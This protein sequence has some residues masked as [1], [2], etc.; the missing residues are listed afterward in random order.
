MPQKKLRGRLKDKS[1]FIVIAEL[2]GGPDFSFGPVEKFLS[3]Y[4]DVGSSF[5]AEGFDFV[6]IASPHN[7]GGTPN[8]ET[9]N[10]LS[11]LRAQGLLGDLDFIPHISCKDQNTDALIS[12]LAG[13]RAMNIETVLVVTGD[14]PIKGKGVFEL[15]SIGLLQ[16]VKEMN[17][18]SYRKVSL[19]RLEDVHQFFA[20]AVVS[21]FKYTEASLL[22]QYYKMEK[23]ITCN[24]EFLITQV[25]W[26]WKKSIELFR[27]LEENG[28]DIPVIGNVFLLST[29][30]PAPRLMHGLKLPG[31]FVSDRLFAKVC[32]E[33]LDKHIERAAQQVAMYKSIGAAG[34]D[35]GS[36][37]DF[38]IFT[39]IL[40]QASEIGDGW[41]EY[42]DNIY[43]PK[44][45]G[46]YLYDD[47]GQR[48]A[49]S[50][51][52]KRFK[53]KC[54]DFLHRNF[55]SPDRRTFHIIK[56][57][58][59]FLQAQNNQGFAY[60]VFTA[61]EYVIKRFFFDCEMCGD[62]Y[63]PENF[64]LCTI[65]G[66][67]KGMANVPCGDATV[68]GYCGNNF[69]LVCIGELIYKAA[70]SESGGIEQWRAT[71]NKPRIHSLEQTSSI[72]N[73][74][75]GRDH[76]AKGTLISIGESIHA[77]IPKVAKMMKL[78][79]NS[80]AD[81]YSKSSGLL[82]YFKAVIESQAAKNADYI[83]VN[84]DAIAEKN[85]QL[86]VD[87]MVEYV[88]MIRNW[89]KTIP[90]CI[91]SNSNKIVIAGL[92]EWYKTGELIK[93][94]LISTIKLDAMD[95]ILS[96]KKSYDFKFV[97]LLEDIEQPA[98]QIASSSINDLHSFARQI[99]DKAVRE[100]GFKPGEIFFELGLSPL[101]EDLPADDNVGGHT[102]VT[103]EA[104]KKIKQDPQM[105]G[106]CCLIRASIAIQGLPGRR[107]GVCRAYLTR[108]MEYGLDAAFVD[109]MHQ[110]AVVA[111]DLELLDLVDAYATM[112]GSPKSKGKA[113]MLIDRFCQQ[114]QKEK[115]KSC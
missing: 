41:R 70:A 35:I 51:P 112:D 6:G 59:V 65:G 1:G 22:Q 83:A 55:M 19:E 76:T 24:A 74:L 79:H 87:M 12:S 101:S 25:G 10:V 13:F 75:F 95:E 99:F 68:D 67:E 111:P 48:V 58:M 113:V 69:D 91:D 44:E 29:S 100:Y 30:T 92:K 93:P 39:Q 115:V 61:L 4:K 34:V 89:G 114:N 38:Q 85:E 86:A 103:F 40:E 52:K 7:P 56:K 80:G 90:I 37:H 73:Y 62:C 106:S 15:E 3:A 5:V 72:L 57:V 78:L 14:K 53:Q 45:D 9:A 43:W 71:I 17:V 32:S 96:L 8:I 66:C 54:F 97:G 108:A 107:I 63:L 31:C 18:E 109:V 36:V 20:G 82:D 49:L 81:G 28:L 21:P 11:Y 94:P 98:G 16:K 88:R 84:L 64:G 33:S 23:K 26:D 47:V 102:Y 50:K 27:Y 60:K 104:I 2:T 105:K 110:Y 46:F 77:S 42:K